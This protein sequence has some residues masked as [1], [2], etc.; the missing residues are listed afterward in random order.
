MGAKTRTFVAPS[1]SP[2]RE[3]ILIDLA[4]EIE[5]EEMT[6]AE[7]AEA[8]AARIDEAINKKRRESDSYYRAASSISERFAYGQPILVGHHSERRQ[9]KTVT[10]WTR[11]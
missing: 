5:P 1:W 7:R 3:D 4:G 6:L 10:A 9:G 8:K 11:P 2:D